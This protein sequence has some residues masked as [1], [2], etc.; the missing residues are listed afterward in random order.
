MNIVR[1]IYHRAFNLVM[2]MMIPLFPY[3]EPELIP[4]LEG[5]TELIRAQGYSRVMIVTDKGIRNLGLTAPLE[6]LIEENGLGLTVYDGTLPNPTSDNVE[7]A[8]ALYLKNECEALIAFGGGSAMDCAKAVGARIVRP[9][10]P[11]KKMQG[12]IKVRHRLPLFIAI[13]TT[14]GTGSETTVASVI[15]DS[16][17]HHKYVINDFSLIPHYALLDPMVTVGLPKHLTATTGMDALTHAVEVYIGKS[18]TKGTKLASE[19]AV[20][21]IFDNLEKAYENGADVEARRNML[22]ASYLAGTAFTKSYVGYIHAVAHTLGGK[23]G[24]PHGLAN[25][26]LLPKVLRAYGNDVTSSLSELA[27][28]VG[29]VDNGVADEVARETFISHVEAM[30]ERMGIPNKLGEI[31]KEDIPELAKTADKEANPLY[32][33]PTLWDAKELEQLY[34]M[35][36]GFDVNYKSESG[37]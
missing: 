32:P 18:R 33:V 21:L 19:K 29:L 11:L 37:R 3:R 26:V 20:K 2:R 4:E 1:K 6:K 15:T 17:T 34:R 30:N 7:E 36:A 9:K 5:V 27:R 13:P 35:C 31:R 16:A 23:Y 8:R 24:V 12:L 28:A 14:A 10:M 25:A 22:E